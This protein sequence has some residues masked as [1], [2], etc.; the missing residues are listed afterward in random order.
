MRYLGS[1]VGR[2]DFRWAAKQAKDAVIPCCSGPIFARKRGDAGF[3]LRF[4]AL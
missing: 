4:L 1:S 3:A 2:F